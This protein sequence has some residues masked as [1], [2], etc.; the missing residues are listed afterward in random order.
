MTSHYWASSD[1]STPAKPGATPEMPTSPGTTQEVTAKTQ[2]SP[3]HGNLPHRGTAVTIL[4]VVSTCRTTVLPTGAPQSPVERETIPGSSM[5]PLATLVAIPDTNH[6]THPGPTWDALTDHHGAWHHSKEY[7]KVDDH[8][9]H[10]QG[11]QPSLWDPLLAHSH[12]GSHIWNRGHVTSHCW[13]PSTLGEPGSYP[14]D[15]SETWNQ[16]KGHCP[17]PDAVLTSPMIFYHSYYHSLRQI[18]QKSMPIPIF[19]SPP[20]ILSLSMRLFLCLKPL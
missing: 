4:E 3:G 5:V 9:R 2:M 19:P 7:P 16:S 12:P 11:T 10:L 6:T 8:S 15:T 13:A 17:T 14:R 1:P 18:Y 20:Y